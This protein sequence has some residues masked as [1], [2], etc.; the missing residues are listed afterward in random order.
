MEFNRRTLLKWFGVGG[1]ALAGE[2]VLPASNLISIPSE[3]LE[4]PASYA[5]A[6]RYDCL[7]N[8]ELLKLGQSEFHEVF[9]VPGIAQMMEGFER[10]E[11]QPEFLDAHEVKAAH[12]QARISFSSG[13]VF[14]LE[15][16]VSPVHGPQASLFA[17]VKEKA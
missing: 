16:T 4:L 3:S 5:Q 8:R 12:G 14:I 10:L 15:R 17:M 9:V 7:L 13:K 11:D 6:F 2:I 1:A